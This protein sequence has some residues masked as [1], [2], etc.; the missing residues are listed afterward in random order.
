[1]LEILDLDLPSIAEFSKDVA[2]CL[3]H[4]SCISTE[5]VFLNYMSLKGRLFELVVERGLM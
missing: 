5:F 4:G 2:F 3:V 1:M